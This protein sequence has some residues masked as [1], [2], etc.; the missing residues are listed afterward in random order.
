[1]NDTTKNTINFR[2][3]QQAA[4]F[5]H[6]LQG[7]FSDGHWENTMPFD[8]WHPWCEATAAV[9]P[10]HL[11]RNFPAYRDNYNLVSKDLLEAVGGRMI[12][13][14]RIAQSN[15]D[16]ELAAQL[17]CCADFN[18]EED[19][20]IDF[21]QYKAN[22]HKFAANENADIGTGKN[23]NKYWSSK[24]DNCRWDEMETAVREL[25][26]MAY[27]MKE[28]KVDLRDMKKIFKDYQQRKL[29]TV[30]E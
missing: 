24:R 6:E 8:H 14:A 23:V 18:T 12:V 28:L 4:L 11:G 27:G 2:N 15:I 10:E 16:D 25:N 21:F 26:V 13:I 29:L 20:T 7:Q 5:T 19:G 22:I 1:M 17:R 30:V 3:A 9:D